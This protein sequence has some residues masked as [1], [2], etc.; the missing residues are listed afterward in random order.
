MDKTFLR[1]EMLLGREA[2]DRLRRSHVAVFGLGG[3]GSYAAE[4]LARSGVGAL[5]LVDQDAF[6]ESNVTRQLALLEQNGFITRQRSENDRRTV[7]V[8]P[9]EKAQQVLEPIREVFRQWRE[10]LFCGL[11]ASER[12]LLEELMER[13]ARRS[14]AIL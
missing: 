3:V 8:Y 6:S 11:D 10:E 2:M 9:T 5:T 1:S 7:E 12:E 4:V 14:E 13:L